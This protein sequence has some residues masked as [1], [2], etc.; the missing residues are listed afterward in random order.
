MFKYLIFTEK[1]EESTPAAGFNDY[2]D[3][4]DYVKHYEDFVSYEPL[5]V[6]NTEEGEWEQES[7]DQDDWDITYDTWKEDQ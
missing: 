4:E 5:H 7:S 6:Y 2:A 3:V 1:E